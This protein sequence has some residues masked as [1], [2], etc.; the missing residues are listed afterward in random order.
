ME[1]KGGYIYLLT[2]PS[3]P[4]WVKI[5]YADNVEERV[6]ELNRTEC[7][8]FAF[9][10]YATYRVDE[11]LKDIDIHNMIDV[12]NPKLRSIDDVDGKIRKREFYLLSPEDFYAMFESMAKA[13]GCMD[14]LVRYE[15]SKEEKS[16]E[17]IA[18]KAETVAKNRHHFKEIEFYSSLTG[19]MYVGKAHENG[20]LL[21]YEKD[22]GEEVVNNANPSKKAIIGKAIIDLGGTTSYGDTT[23][24]RYHKLMKLVGDKK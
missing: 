19:K 20:T 2:N 3:F 23:Y 22:S 10:I 7:T 17:K 8:P 9:R 6:K 4:E 1:N 16:D 11:R 14:R 21:I 13:H 24:Q 18:I 5:G 15:K 12:I